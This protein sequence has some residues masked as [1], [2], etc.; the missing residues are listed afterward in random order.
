MVQ[1]FGHPKCKGTRAA[2]RF[3]S[4]RRVQ[5]QS[6]DLHDKGMS[7]GELD[8]VARALSIEAL[9]DAGGARAKERGLTHLGPDKARIQSLL[10][11]DPRLF[12]TPIVRR[13]P[14]ASVGLDEPAWKAFAEAERG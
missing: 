5:V 10:L 12:R 14:K 3:F 1:V 6:I 8:S 2:L 11:E 13:G 9:Y 7:K 4:E